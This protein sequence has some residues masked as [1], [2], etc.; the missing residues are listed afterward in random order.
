MDI[1]YKANKPLIYKFN[2]Y[3]IDYQSTGALLRTSQTDL[4]LSHLTAT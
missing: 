3:I 4:S 2:R 1:L